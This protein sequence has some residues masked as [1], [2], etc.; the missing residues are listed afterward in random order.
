MQPLQQ[1]I[2]CL[3]EANACLPDFHDVHDIPYALSACLFWRSNANRLNDDYDDAI[4]ILD[5]IITSHSSADDPDLHS[6]ATPAAGLA[7]TLAYGCFILYKKPDYLEEAIFAVVLIQAHCLFKIQTTM[8]S[9]S[10]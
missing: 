4:S 3:H 5:R 10:A 7:A 6:R 2:E 8:L 1:L 9:L